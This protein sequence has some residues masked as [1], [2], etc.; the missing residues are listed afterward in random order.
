MVSRP[1]MVDMNG[2]IAESADVLPA[3]EPVAFGLEHA[4]LSAAIANT[5]S[6]V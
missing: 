6:H 5:E 2:E 1:E 3:S 4:S